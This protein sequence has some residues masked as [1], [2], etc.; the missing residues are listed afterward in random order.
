MIEST[1]LMESL[2]RLACTSLAIL[3]TRLEL[4]SNELEEERLRIVQMLLYASLALFFLGLAITM[5][6]AFFV[7]LFWDSHPLL[8]LGGFSA[9]Y[10]LAGL[11]AW[12]ELNRAARQKS[13]LF[14][15]SLAELA[16]DHDRLAH[17]P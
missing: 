12:N 16:D 1:G 6:T 15:N 13:K 4:L 14:S 9:L 2:K 3:Q 7:I 17:L 10:F 8:V 5:L 11:M